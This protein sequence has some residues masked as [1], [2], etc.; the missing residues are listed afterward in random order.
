MTSCF[1]SEVCDSLKHF[2]KVDYHVIRQG[3]HEAVLTIYEHLKTRISESTQKSNKA[4][5]A[6]RRCSQPHLIFI[7]LITQ[8][9][10]FDAW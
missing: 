1:Q 9:G 10:R 4:V 2:T 6:V 3:L 7:K 8:Y 5:V